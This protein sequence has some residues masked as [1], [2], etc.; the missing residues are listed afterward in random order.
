MPSSPT[1][2]PAP[3]LRHGPSYAPSQRA[4]SGAP[5][6]QRSPSYSSQ[7]AEAPAS[8]P[9]SISSVFKAISDGAR[10]FNEDVTRAAAVQKAT[11]ELEN[12][13]DA[14]RTIIEIS[15]DSAKRT[16][17]VEIRK[18]D[19]RFRELNEQ[20]Y[21]RLGKL[22]AEARTDREDPPRIDR[23]LPNFAHDV[24]HNDPETEAAILRKIDGLR[25]DRE[26]FLSGVHVQLA[27]DPILYKHFVKNVREFHGDHYLA[28]LD[29]K[30]SLGKR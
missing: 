20:N 1:A 3:A 15:I 8:Q 12:D 24:R 17:E 5:A 27:G 6:S 11:S 16:K 4:P 21:E 28:G 14:E 22:L 18:Q 29:P 7:K 10:Q 26:D 13:L 2:T 23:P 9:F 25:S 19:P 30:S